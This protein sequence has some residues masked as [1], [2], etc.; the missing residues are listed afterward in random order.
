[1]ATITTDSLVRQEVLP[2][3][4]KTVTYTI[5]SWN[6]GTC[7]SSFQVKLFSLSAPFLSSSTSSTTQAVYR[8]KVGSTYVFNVGSPPGGGATDI[9]IVGYQ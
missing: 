8:G 9:A 5:A 6:M 3:A 2:N 1:M 4:P 7:I